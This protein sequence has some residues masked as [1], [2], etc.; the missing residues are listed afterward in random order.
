M[1]YIVTIRLSKSSDLAVRF[2][3]RS[4]SSYHFPPLGLWV[5]SMEHCRPLFT[6]RSWRGTTTQTSEVPIRDPETSPN[7]TEAL[8]PSVRETSELWK[9]HAL[10]VSSRFPKKRHDHVRLSLSSGT[11]IPE[12]NVSPPRLKLYCPRTLPSHKKETLHEPPLKH[13]QT[14]IHLD[15]GHLLRSRY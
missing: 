10:S 12:I 2:S 9:E 8:R 3:N 5:P 6:A 4:A 14:H 15:H 1:V 7:A 11:H 13:H